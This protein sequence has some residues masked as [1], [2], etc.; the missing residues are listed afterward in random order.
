MATADGALDATTKTLMSLLTDALL[1]HPDGVAAI[2]DRA[3]AEEVS[4]AESAQTVCMAF[5]TGGVPALV[6]GLRA[7]RKRASTS[8]VLETIPE[9]SALSQAPH[10][11]APVSNRT[12]QRLRAESEFPCSRTEHPLAQSQELFPGLTR[13]GVWLWK[14]SDGVR[15]IAGDAPDIGAYEL[16]MASSG[17]PASAGPSR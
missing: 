5:T 13:T 2:A 7:F 16:G 17:P 9:P 1:A 10:R 4:D 6:T 3:R 8:P 15:E 14:R 11:W 12:C